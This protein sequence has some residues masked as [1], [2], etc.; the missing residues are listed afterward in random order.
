MPK[1]IAMLQSK[2]YPQSTHS[3][4]RNNAMRFSFEKLITANHNNKKKTM[5]AMNPLL[6][7]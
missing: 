6:E 5:E 2:G 1:N 4:S 7:V 3:S